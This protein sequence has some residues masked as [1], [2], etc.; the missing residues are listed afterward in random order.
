[1][2]LRTPVADGCPPKDAITQK[3]IQWASLQG[4]DRDSGNDSCDDDGGSD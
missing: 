4:I 2:D 3:L 1:V